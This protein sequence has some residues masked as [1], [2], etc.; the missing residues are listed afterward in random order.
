VNNKRVIEAMIL[1]E[2]RKDKRHK[3]D[4]EMERRKLEFEQEKLRGTM[5][6]GLG[7]IGALNSSSDALKQ[8]AAALTAKSSQ[9]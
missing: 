3:E 4:M 5:Q 1:C 9:V 6:L 2:D 7:Y 8:L